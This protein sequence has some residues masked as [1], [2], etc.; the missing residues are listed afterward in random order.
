MAEPTQISAADLERTPGGI[1]QRLEARFG[2]GA[3]PHKRRAF[4]LRLQMLV[5]ARPELE[6]LIKEAAS[7]ASIARNPDRY[8]CRAV[9]MKLMDAAKGE[10]L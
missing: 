5:S 2:L 1:A 9:R 6:A 8:F 4:Y 10:S 3:D 7:Q